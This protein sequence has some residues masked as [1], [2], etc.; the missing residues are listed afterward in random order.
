MSAIHPVYVISRFLLF[1]HAHEYK[2]SSPKK[3]RT[4]SGKRRSR[5]R[6]MATVS[7]G[8]D[9]RDTSF[10]IDIDDVILSRFESGLTLNLDAKS[11]DNSEDEFTLPNPWEPDTM[12]ITNQSAVENGNV[13]SRNLIG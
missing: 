8:I 10:T 12:V 7:E 11:T 2:K 4:A 5:L 9:V 1:R 3:R 6:K 13:S